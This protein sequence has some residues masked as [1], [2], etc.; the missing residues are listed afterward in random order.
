MLL[1]S[2]GACFVKVCPGAVFKLCLVFFMNGLLNPNFVLCSSAGFFM[3][4]GLFLWL[5][6]DLLLVLSVSQFI[7][8]I[9]IVR[10]YFFIYVHWLWQCG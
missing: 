2:P 9:L 10:S 8:M 4:V 7:F 5:G 6:L 3:T 1:V